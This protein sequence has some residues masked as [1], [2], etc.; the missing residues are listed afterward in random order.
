MNNSLSNEN[1]R[2]SDVPAVDASIE[3]IFAFALTFN[4]YANGGFEACA[5]IARKRLHGNLTELRTCLFFQQRTYRHMGEMPD[6]EAQG[7]TRRLIGIIRNQL[8]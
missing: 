4:G 1:L 2:L 7:Y 3:E 8:C 5:E 6:A